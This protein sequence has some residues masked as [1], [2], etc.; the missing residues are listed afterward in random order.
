LELSSAVA[1]VTLFRALT[2][3]LCLS[4]G[5]VFLFLELRRGKGASTAHTSEHF[6]EL[7]PEYNAQFRP[8]VWNYLL[9]K[10]VGF[11][12]EA[13]P[14]PERAGFGLD[15]GCGLGLQGEAMVQR[16]FRMVGIDP[17]TICCGTD[18]ARV[19]PRPWGTRS[20]C[21]SPTGA[22]ASSTRWASCTTWRTRRPRRRPVVRSC[23]C[24]N[25]AGRWWSRRPTRTTAVP[26]LHGLRVPILSRIDEGTEHWIEPARWAALPGFEPA[27]LRFFTFLPDFIPQGLMPPFL[28]L[29]RKLEGG[30]LKPYS[31]HYQAVL[32]KPA[33]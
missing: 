25:P 17:A 24:S 15:L 30:P 3:G 13:L 9:Q 27:R 26:L 28:A 8:H 2:T 6:D 29:E 21:P 31:V 4:V 32:K 20:R 16:G 14:P 10:R 18:G 22:F 1:T 33:G 23:A 19:S 12:A 5:A 7:A 11:M